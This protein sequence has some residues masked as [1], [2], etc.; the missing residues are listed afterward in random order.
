M[1]C[2]AAEIVLNRNSFCTVVLL[3][4]VPQIRQREADA[5]QLGNSSAWTEPIIHPLTFHWLQQVTC[6]PP[7]N[8]MKL[9]KSRPWQGSR[10]SETSLCSRRHLGIF[11][12]HGPS[13]PQQT[14]RKTTNSGG[15]AQEEYTL[16]RESS[17]RERMC[18]FGTKEKSNG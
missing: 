10:L 8:A 6:P 14:G 15:K 9:G 5:H 2:S 17:R 18:F 3:S 7:P 12:V 4:R 1:S 13:P 11:G 16:W